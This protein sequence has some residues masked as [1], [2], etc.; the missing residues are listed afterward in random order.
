MLELYFDL[1]S[2]ID[3]LQFNMVQLC[4]KNKTKHW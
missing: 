1:I 3:C 4:S 2:E